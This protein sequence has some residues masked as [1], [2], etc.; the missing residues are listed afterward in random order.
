M[1]AAAVV[2]AASSS[3]PYAV[4]SASDAAAAA[5]PSGSS[6]AATKRRR[7][8][9]TTT[10]ANPIPNSGGAVVVDAAAQPPMVVP[11]AP[12]SAPILPAPSSINSVGN[13][14]GMTMVH[15]LNAAKPIV[16]IRK[17]EGAKR[18]QMKYDPSIP[19]TKE[20]TSAWRREQRRKRNRESAAACRKRQRDRISELEAEVNEWK[21][22]F[23]EALGQL[24]EV[25]GAGAKELERELAE[26]ASMMPSS[27]TSAPPSKSLTSKKNVTKKRTRCSTPPN[28]SPELPTSS[29]TILPS[30]ASLESHIVTPF[31]QRPKFLP[32]LVTSSSSSSSSPAS[33]DD[34]DNIRFPILEDPLLIIK[35]NHPQGNIIASPKDSM[36]LV[37]PPRVENR[38]HNQQKQHLKE[39]ITRPAVK[40]TGAAATTAVN[41]PLGTTTTSIESVC[42]ELLQVVPDS[43]LSLTEKKT[44]PFPEA[45]PSLVVPTTEGGGA[46]VAGPATECL[47]NMT[48]AAAAA[49]SV[50]ASSSSG[51]DIPGV[52]TDESDEDSDLGEF[53]LDAVQW[54]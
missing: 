26:M 32:P 13:V 12:I 19:M 17:T 1:A 15:P 14:S 24:R 38:Q 2:S 16:T 33:V 47:M 36:H 27:V 48:A 46:S 39:K 11:S 7:V 51:E 21:V 8:T 6:S 25:D 28:V 35:D 31:D 41:T 20:E 10:T 49:S 4:V 18:P 30:Q 54:L 50:S 45:C 29:M 3:I 43:C 42:D 44:M 34:I 53:L 52:S 5:V 40:I 23:D 9:T 37:V 22:R